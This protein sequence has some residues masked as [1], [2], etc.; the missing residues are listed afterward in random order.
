MGSES[1]AHEAKGRTAYS[2]SGHEN[3]T[4]L[5]KHI[6]QLKDRKQEY[7]IT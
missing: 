4:E 2:L 1:I 5:S 7:D 3:E 6:R